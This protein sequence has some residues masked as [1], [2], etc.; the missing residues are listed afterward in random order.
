MREVQAKARELQNK[1]ESDSRFAH[2]AENQQI[3]HEK[4]EH[5]KSKHAPPS[6]ASI[7]ELLGTIVKGGWLKNLLS[8]F[9]IASSLS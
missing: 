8:A 7:G 5:Y 9:R 3:G 4:A 6:Q 2:T 1:S